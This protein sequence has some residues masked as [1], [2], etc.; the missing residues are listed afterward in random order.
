[1]QY[2]GRC[3]PRKVTLIGCHIRNDAIDYRAMKMNNATLAM[4]RG[5]VE[6]A[7]NKHSIHQ[8]EG[9]EPPH[10]CFNIWKKKEEKTNP[11]KSGCGILG[12]KRI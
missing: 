11:S 1:M 5:G 3:T 10:Q 6:E 4:S 9:K 2:S 8:R 12:A 7:T